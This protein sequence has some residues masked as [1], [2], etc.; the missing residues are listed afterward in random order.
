M[1]NSIP[2]LVLF[3]DPDG[4]PQLLRHLGKRAPV[5]AIV[6]AS[7]RPHQHTRLAAM[8]DQRGCPFLVQPTW[9]GSDYP[10][11]VDAIRDIAPDLIL[12]NSYAMILRPDVLAIPR[13][14]AINVHGAL[15]PE[16]RGA[17]PVE[18]A[19][20]GGARKTGVTVHRVDAGIDTGDIVAREEVPIYFEDTWRDVRARVNRATDRVLARMLPLILAG[21]APRRR[22]DERRAAHF[23]RRRAEDG[24][25]E[26]A[27]PLRRI[28]N[29]VRA[30]VA[31]HPGAWSDAAGGKILLDRFYT[32]SELA[33]LK[34]DPD[35]GGQTLAAAGVALRPVSATRAAGATAP[36]VAGAA[37]SRQRRR[38]ANRALAFD[39]S[40][41]ATGHGRC[42]LRNIDYE[43]GTAHLALRVKRTAP[44]QTI[45]I[46]T[47]LVTAFAKRELGLRRVSGGRRSV[48]P[49]RQ[50]ACIR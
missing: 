28:Y 16:Q 26:W 13:R 24:R 23:A 38:R 44:A 48:R 34:Y 10:A 14:G 1:A 30:V 41:G 20:L 15:L 40:I 50:R 3:G 12:V 25:F 4:I 36:R 37:A 5:A 22:Q 43:R 27:W 45:G 33:A 39:I 17:N 7:I 42:A 47:T 35:R 8:A 18:W 46:V 9:Q 11:F 31:P 2:R 49:A 29:L 21:R 32:L 6:G 19:L